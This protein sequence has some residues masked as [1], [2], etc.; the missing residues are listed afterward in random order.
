MQAGLSGA[1]WARAHSA[2]G[3]EGPPTSGAV[4][5]VVTAQGVW[6]VCQG[7]GTWQPSHAAHMCVP[8]RLATS[9]GSFPSCVFGEPEEGGQIPWSFD[10]IEVVI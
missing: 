9:L 1:P 4:V 8:G 6:Q 5:S 3:M 2:Q 7:L 10:D